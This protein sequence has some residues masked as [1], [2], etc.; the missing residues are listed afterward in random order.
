MKIKKAIVNKNAARGLGKIRRA[1]GFS[2]PEVAISSFLVIFFT[3]LSADLS[4]LIF[5][6]SVNDKACR[7]VVRAAAN[8][9]N[10][11]QALQFAIAET[12][13]HKTDGFFISPI[14]LVNGVNYQDFGGNPPA[15][16]CPYVQATTSV[17][18]NLPMPLYFFGASFT[19]QVQFSQCYTSP[20][21]KTKYTLN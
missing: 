5:A 9:P 12:K 21:I 18:V 13:M 3:V 7:D 10:A 19:N 1:K 17:N 8:Q 16:Q 11:N 2:F 6:C 14:Q 15:G 20:I 4:L